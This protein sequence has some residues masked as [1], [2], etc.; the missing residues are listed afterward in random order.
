ML[1]LDSHFHWWEDSSLL[2]VDGSKCFEKNCGLIGV[3]VPRGSWEESMLSK[4][5]KPWNVP[6][7]ICPCTFM[8]IHQSLNFDEDYSLWIW[9]NR[10]FFILTLLPVDF[11]KQECNIYIAPFSN[12]YYAGN[13]VYL[14]HVTYNSICIYYV[15]IQT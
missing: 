15:L 10:F 3:H 13:S 8:I 9:E 2:N 11:D 5:R 1:T 6:K 7:G 4:P 14:K 12:I